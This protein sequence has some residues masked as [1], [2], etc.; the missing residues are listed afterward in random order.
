MHEYAPE[1]VQI[2]GCV[3]YA[4]AEWYAPKRTVFFL[5][6]LHADVGLCMNTHRGSRCQQE[7]ACEFL[8]CDMHT[9]ASKCMKKYTF[10]FWLSQ[11]VS[12]GKIGCGQIVFVFCLFPFIDASWMMRW[13]QENSLWLEEFIPFRNMSGN[14][15]LF[16]PAKDA[17][18]SAGYVRKRTGR[19]PFQV[20]CQACKRLPT[21][22]RPMRTVFYR[23][24]SLTLPILL[25][26]GL[27]R[28]RNVFHS[29]RCILF[30]LIIVRVSIPF[31]CLGFLTSPS[32]LS[33]AFRPAKDAPGGT[34]I[35]IQTHQ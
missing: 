10:F 25:F 6:R 21:C 28:L 14:S 22:S 29:N 11:E 32:P 12:V 24:S 4:H 15:A 8:W 9:N 7:N 35:C 19:L 23:C 31:S 17:P 2:E 18:G 5:R 34:T 30:F 3:W 13:M 20:N 16:R 1:F 27:F 26:I 33:S